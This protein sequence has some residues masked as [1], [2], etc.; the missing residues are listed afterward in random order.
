MKY[1]ET[2]DEWKMRLPYALFYTFQISSCYFVALIV[3]LRMSIIQNPTEFQELHKKIAKPLSILIWVLVFGLYSFPAVPLTSRVINDDYV[4]DILIFLRL[5]IGVTLPISFAI[6]VNVYLLF[7]LRRLKSSNRK[8]VRYEQS[9]KSSFQKLIN[10]L[11][12]W[13]IV[14]NAPFVAWYHYHLHCLR[15]YKTP[16]LSTSGVCYYINYYKLINNCQKR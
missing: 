12:I 1:W 16:W 14:C 2:D 11:L 13:M 10:G 15:E 3:F 6:L 4:S 7:Y 5:H 8:C 9:E